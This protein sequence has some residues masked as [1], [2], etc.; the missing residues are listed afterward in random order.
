MSELRRDPI[1]GRWVI[2][3]TERSGRPTD[4][5]SA[6]ADL[7]SGACPFCPGEEAETPPEVYVERESGP[8]NGPGWTIRVVSNKFPALGDD[9]EFELRTEGL[10]EFSH[11]VGA[12]EVIIESPGHED[13]L[14]DLPLESYATLIRAI[15]ARFLD[16]GRDSRFRTIQVFKNSGARAGA[17]LSHGHTQ[18]MA[19]PIVP[20]HLEE[21]IAGFGRHFEKQQSCLLCDILSEERERQARII[22]E[23]DEFVALAPFASRLPYETLLV[24]KRHQARFEEAD[25]AQVYGLAPA[26]QELLARMANRLEYPPYNLC[27]H[28]APL[29]GGKSFPCFHWHWELLPRL[30]KV[31]GF[32]WGTGI[33]INSTSPEVAAADLRR[34]R[35]KA[36]TG[37]PD[38]G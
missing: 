11:G 38:K 23:T 10:F 24:P 8:A 28:T 34:V 32:E 29:R 27:L 35:L 17:T 22:F 30:S 26:L 14:S 12:H 37:G 7:T 15:R 18:L 33:Y 2:L 5:V 6:Q 19:T 9:G 13:R 25:D 1:S 20:P 4:F 16:L 21:K 36:G 3:A 31:A